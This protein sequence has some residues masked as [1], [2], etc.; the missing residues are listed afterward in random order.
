MG[1][2]HGVKKPSEVAKLHSKLEVTLITEHP[3]LLPVPP[4]V[5][6]SSPVLI[7]CLFTSV[8]LEMTT[9]CSGHGEEA[10]DGPEAGR[11]PGPLPGCG[12]GAVRRHRLL[13]PGHNH[14]APLPEKV[15]NSPRL[16]PSSSHS[17]TGLVYQEPQPSSYPSP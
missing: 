6:Y 16:P 3:P 2:L 15:R 17:P 10:G 4:S 13:Y 11:D 14:A 9:A 1:G 5:G 7:S 8:A 12:H